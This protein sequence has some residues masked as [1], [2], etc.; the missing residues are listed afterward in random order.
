M[1]T[2]KRAI[3]AVAGLL[4][5][6]MSGAAATAPAQ[7]PA[8]PPGKMSQH[9]EGMHGMMGTPHHVLAMAH[10]DNLATFATALQEH[11]AHSKTVDLE[12]ARPALAEMRRSFDQMQSHHQ[13]QMARMPMT[14]DSTKAPMQHMETHL[15]ELGKHL[16][17]LDS[18]VNAAA[19]DVKKVLDATAGILAQCADMHAKAKPHTIHQ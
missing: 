18:E 16:A 10:H 17:A 19:P 14:A 12:L 7:S 1:K 5:V 15:A 2:S 6:L 9:M 3:S 11:V 13:A 4:A 8:P